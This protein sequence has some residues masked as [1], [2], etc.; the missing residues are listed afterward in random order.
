VLAPDYLVLCPHIGFQQE[1]AMLDTSRRDPV[2]A[3]SADSDSILCLFLA[4]LAAMSAAQRNALLTLLDFLNG[5]PRE[6]LALFAK[7]AQPHL[8]DDE[9]AQ[10]CGVTSRTVR[11][12]ERYQAFK[13]KAADFW[14][15]Q[16]QTCYQEDDS[17]A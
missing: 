2:P 13:P 9:V 5:L 17:A 14:A 12:W 16:R 7:A 11:R 8:T 1:L 4:I 10:L 3:A 6:E 15:S